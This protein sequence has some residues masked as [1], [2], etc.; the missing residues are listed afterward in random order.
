MSKRIS[1]KL[2]D[3]NDWLVEAINKELKLKSPFRIHISRNASGQP[4]IGWHQA[5]P[6]AVGYAIMD[7][8]KLHNINLNDNTPKTTVFKRLLA[9]WK[10]KRNEDYGI[11]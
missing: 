10:I 5:G 6:C 3:K 8:C 11:K 4:V 1:I 7:Y 2:T 9:N